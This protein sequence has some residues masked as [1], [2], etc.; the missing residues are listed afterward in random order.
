M[1]R[2]D[3]LNIF[4]SIKHVGSIMENA[5]K[6]FM[7]KIIDYAGLFPPENLSMDSAIQNYLKYNSETDE[8]MLSRF[9]CL[10]YRL[11]ELEKYRDDFRLLKK[12]LQF[13]LLG[14]GGKNIDEFVKTLETDLKLLL[15]FVEYHQNSVTVD[16]YEARFPEELIEESNPIRITEFL[17]K[18]AEIIGSRTPNKIMPFYE[19]A[20][21]GEWSKT[22]E[23]IVEGISY[24]NIHVQSKPIVK[25]LPAG[26]KLRCGGV[27]PYMYPSPEQI[28]FVI[29]SCKRHQIA[30]KATAGMHHPLR[31]FN[32]TEQVKMHGFLNV[33][34]AAILAQNH[35]LN[36][37]RIQSIIEDEEIKNFIF[38]DSEFKW[39][40]LSVTSNQINK[41]REQNMISFGS[42]SFDEPR[43]DL[44]SLGLL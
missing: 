22:I 26:Y 12:P 15:E 41:A 2:F 35:D 1:N 14:S 20:F 25:Y 5:F 17:N 27:E 7:S 10:A 11:K 30:M 3:H 43:E 23:A 24:H 33:F 31:H 9:I 32:E 16:A 13:S 38:T 21:L 34:G 39:N 19:G 18:V 29:L 6:I 4:D 36:L 44:Q 40:D 37:D 42:C 28:A 8:W